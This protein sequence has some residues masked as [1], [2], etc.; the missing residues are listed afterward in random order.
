MNQTSIVVPQQI[1]A[2][3]ITAAR[4]KTQLPLARMILL[5][6]FEIGRAHV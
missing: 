4:G 2:A 1:V 5:G 6:M 3:N